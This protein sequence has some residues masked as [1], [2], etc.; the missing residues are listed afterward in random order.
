MHLAWM[1]TPRNQ[2]GIEG[3]KFPLLADYNK[4]NAIKYRVLVPMIIMDDVIEPGKALRGLFIIDDNNIVRY[5]M[6]MTCPWAEV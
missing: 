6:S 4:I 2:G 5:Q 1:T 3:L